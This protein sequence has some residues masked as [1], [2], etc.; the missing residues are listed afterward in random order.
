MELSSLHWFLVRFEGLPS[1][2]WVLFVHIG[3]LCQVAWLVT[4]VDDICW[5]VRTTMPSANKKKVI[6]I[7]MVF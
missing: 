4:F 7:K 2:E 1:L 3:I 6:Y 5:P